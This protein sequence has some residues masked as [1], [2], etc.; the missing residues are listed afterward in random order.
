VL[1]AA[2]QRAVDE[3]DDLAERGLVRHG[4]DRE[5]TLLRDLDERR[6]HA[7]EAEADAEA[8]RGHAAGLELGDECALGLGVA[9]Q[10]HP[11]REHDPVATQPARRLVDLHG[12]G[13]EHLP[14]RRV[15]PSAEQLQAERV[16]GQQAGEVKA[17]SG[18][19]CHGQPAVG[20]ARV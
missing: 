6:W 3:V 17:M 11:G 4:E 1:L 16:L 5:R 15:G 12:V 14:R 10:P 18:C 13:A 20:R 2:G 9:P 8:Q 7:L 19:L